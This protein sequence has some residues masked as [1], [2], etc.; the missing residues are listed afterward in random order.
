MSPAGILCQA[1]AALAPFTVVFV[2]LACCGLPGLAG[3]LG[4]DDAGPGTMSEAASAAPNEPSGRACMRS[5][6]SQLL[7]TENPADLLDASRLIDLAFPPTAE[8]VTAGICSL[9]TSRATQWLSA[10]GGSM[11]GVLPG[12]VLAD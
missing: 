1:P 5:E 6:G 11:V 2:G 4:A 9:M 12:D 7:V 10:Q 3:A 8:A